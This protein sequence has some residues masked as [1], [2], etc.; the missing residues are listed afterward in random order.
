M[1]RV[2]LD[3]AAKRQDLPIEVG[4][5][6]GNGCDQERRDRSMVGSEEREHVGEGV[7]AIIDRDEDDWIG[8]RDVVD[9]RSDPGRRWECRGGRH[10]SRRGHGAAGCQ[11]ACGPGSRHPPP[12]VTTRRT[13]PRRRDNDSNRGGQDY[14]YP[15]RDQP[16]MTSAPPTALQP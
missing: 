13:Q 4:V 15:G 9:A 7:P 6:P 3:R 2:V 1:H 5:A 11:G 10:R 14:R 8:G 16:P 12:G